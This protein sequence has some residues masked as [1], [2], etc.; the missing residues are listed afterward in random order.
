MNR[1]TAMAR[2]LASRCLRNIVAARLRTLGPPLR[3][4][5]PVPKVPGLRSAVSLTSLI[6]NPATSPDGCL[7][8]IPRRGGDSPWLSGPGES[9]RACYLLSPACHDGSDRDRTGVLDVHLVLRGAL[10]P[11]RRRGVR[12]H[13]ALSHELQAGVRGRRGD[14]A[15]G[16][17]EEVEVHGRQEALQVRRLVDGE[18]DL[19]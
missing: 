12:V 1:I 5:G 11:G 15:A 2:T 10:V 14:Q 13:V 4:S 19:A 7:D 8:V 17:L 18:G 9:P 3:W 6:F 16:E